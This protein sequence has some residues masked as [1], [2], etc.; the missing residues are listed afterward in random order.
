METKTVWVRHVAASL[1]ALVILAGLTAGVAQ[2]A[3]SPRQLYRGLLKAAPASSL[4]PALRG[5]KTRS[6]KLS[7]GA[8]SQHA[9]GAVEVG[10]ADALVGF[11]VF[12]SRAR[13]LA[14]LKAFPP[15]TGPNKILTTELPGLPRPAYLIHAAG[16]GFEVAYVVFVVDN[17]VVNAWAYGAKGSL[18]TL[19]A[20][21]E[22]DARWAKNRTLSVVRS[23]S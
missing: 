1:L 14:D 2:A 4:P 11:L 22:R 13:A 16:N 5:T 12:P 18:K 7:A 3:L 15:D 10:N 8:R 23:S 20:I 9:V 6:A 21:V 19:I 17:V